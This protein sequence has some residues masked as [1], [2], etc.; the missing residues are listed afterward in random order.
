[1]P[2]LLYVS[3]FPAGP[4]HTEDGG[5]GGKVAPGFGKWLPAGHRRG[6]PAV[7]SRTCFPS[8]VPLPLAW[9][10]FTLLG[11]C[12]RVMDQGPPPL[13]QAPRACAEP[14]FAHPPPPPRPCVSVSKSRF[15]P[16]GGTPAHSLPKHL[17]LDAGE[18]SAGPGSINDSMTLGHCLLFQTSD[19]FLT[20]ACRLPTPRVSV[21]IP[22]NAGWTP[23]CQSNQSP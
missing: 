6:D 5:R 9:E 23:T 8:G 15:S 2:R 13:R 7:A 21:S 14:P 4:L 12:Q 10:P 1:M 20:L 16:S 19:N 22:L 18:L 3:V 11:G 17:A